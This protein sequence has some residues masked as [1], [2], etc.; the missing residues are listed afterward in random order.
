[1]CFVLKVFFG[2]YEMLG[3]C[4]LYVRCVLYEVCGVEAWDEDDARDIPIGREQTENES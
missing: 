1:M 3:M 4:V 2:V